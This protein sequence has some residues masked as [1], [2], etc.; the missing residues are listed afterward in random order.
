[1][2]NHLT[3]FPLS[4]VII[5]HLL[6]ML[7]GTRIPQADA[8]PQVHLWRCFGRVFCVHQPYFQHAEPRQSLKN[9]SL[10]I[11]RYQSCT[12]SLIITA[13]RTLAV[14]H[15]LDQY[16]PAVSDRSIL[17]PPSQVDTMVLRFYRC[18]LSHL[19]NYQLR[20]YLPNHTEPSAHSKK[21]I[22]PTRPRRFV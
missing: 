12:H 18:P 21:S 4:F 17:P 5:K 16:C 15:M 6:L 14:Q 3:L 20:S 9:G 13:S 1:M 11:H 7:V 2:K 19:P 10:G 8:H 22:V